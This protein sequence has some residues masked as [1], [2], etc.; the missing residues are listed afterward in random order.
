MRA[1]IMA[2][3]AGLTASIAMAADD[4]QIPPNVPDHVK[5]WFRKVRPPGGGIPCCDVADGHRT[6]YEVRADGYWVPIDG[7]M[8]HVPPEAVIRNMGN[9]VGEAIVWYGRYRPEGTRIQI[10]CFVPGG[11]F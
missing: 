6:D 4:G 10:R 2:A 7:E 9:P 8:H 11:D 3:L 5:E 1:L